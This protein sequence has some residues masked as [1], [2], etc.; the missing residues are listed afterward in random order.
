MTTART[1]QDQW[2][3]AQSKNLRLQNGASSETVSEREK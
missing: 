3:I 1:L 2:L